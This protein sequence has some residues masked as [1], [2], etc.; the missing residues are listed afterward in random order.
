MTDYNDLD[1]SE[2]LAATSSETAISLS[3]SSFI[4]DNLAV[5]LLINYSNSKL[6]VEGEDDSVSSLTTYGLSATYYFGETGLWGQ[7]SYS[8]G[9]LDDG[10][11]DMDISGTGISLGYAWFVSDN[12]SINPSL[13]YFTSNTELDNDVMK[14]AGLSGS[15]I[16]IHFLQN[17][18]SS[19]NFNS[20]INV[21]L[22]SSDNKKS[23][24]DD[25]F[26]TENT[27]P[28]IYTMGIIA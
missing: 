21:D 25:D 5:G 4:I 20:N 27:K 13:G 14:M 24:K 10:A 28:G 15:R 2:F 6:E 7:G 11:E 9:T 17:K 19:D 16:A 3:G 26:I 23:I 22:N 8:M 12:V 18:L 1:E